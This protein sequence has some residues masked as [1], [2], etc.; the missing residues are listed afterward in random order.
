MIKV[1]PC[2][3][4][5]NPNLF[6]ILKENANI[7]CIIKQFSQDTKLKINFLLIGN[8]GIL[9]MYVCASMQI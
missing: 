6:Y 7:K 5:K 9:S 2:M 4:P 3:L 1:A 8:H